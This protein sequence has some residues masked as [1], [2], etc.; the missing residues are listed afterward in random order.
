MEAAALRELVARALAEDLGAGDLTSQATVPAGAR[1]RA[2]IS[3][4]AP[5]AIYGLDA[6]A[7][8]FGQAGAET[9]RAARG[10]G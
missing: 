1:A 9:L 3:Q 7:E 4:K 8:A 6:A 5:G 2:R 10:R